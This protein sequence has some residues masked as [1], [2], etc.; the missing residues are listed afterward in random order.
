MIER[1]TPP[2]QRA[3]AVA[4]LVLVLVVVAARWSGCR[5]PICSAQDAALAAGQRRIAEL[6]AR[7]PAREELLAQE[8]ELQSSLDTERALLPGS[9]P[10]VAAAQLQGDLAGLGRGHGRGD[11]H[12]PDPRA[13]GGGRRSPGSACGSA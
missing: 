1:L 11:H 7:I 3:L 13:R 6:R 4:L 12:R 5:W 8:R 10:A 9:T 2:Q